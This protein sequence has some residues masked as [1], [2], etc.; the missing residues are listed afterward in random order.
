MSALLRNL[1]ALICAAAL[2]LVP[3][4][5][6]PGG[7]GGLVNLPGGGA[8]ASQA[9]SGS[10]CP[11]VTR[12]SNEDLTL[13]LHPTMC[14]SAVAI[15]LPGAPETTTF[16]M[17]ENGRYV[18]TAAAMKALIEAGVSR[19]ELLFAAPNLTFLKVHVTFTE[20]A[21]VVVSFP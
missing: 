5:G 10:G 1:A 8:L 7:K 13:V 21:R 19:V 2:V 12:S 4:L 20:N 18:M 17:T 11:S 15:T 3:V 16:T 6:N 14:G 9:G